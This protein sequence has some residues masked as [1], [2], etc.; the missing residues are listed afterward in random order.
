MP[1]R[2]LKFKLNTPDSVV[3]VLMLYAVAAM[4]LILTFEA[5]TP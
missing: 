2:L 1:C 3:H 4:P 5:D